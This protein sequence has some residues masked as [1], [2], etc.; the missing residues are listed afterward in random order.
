MR[1]VWVSSFLFLFIISNCF[2]TSPQADSNQN[3]PSTRSTTFVV[4]QFGSGDFIKIQD[5]INASKDGDKIVIYSGDYYENLVINNSIEINGSDLDN[6]KL[7]GETQ[8]FG[9]I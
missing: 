4:D 3:A 8:L 1:K 6:V 7:I 9:I 2:F 5:A